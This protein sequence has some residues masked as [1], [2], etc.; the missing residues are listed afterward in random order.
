VEEWLHKF[1]TS[2]L[3]DGELSAS[4]SGWFIV[5][6]GPV[7]HVSWSG[8]VPESVWTFRRREESLSSDE[9]SNLDPSVVHP[10]A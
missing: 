6:E 5:G 1:L 3:D 9:E 7:V 4:Y 8:W 10:I 2:A